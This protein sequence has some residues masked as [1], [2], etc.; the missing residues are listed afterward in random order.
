MKESSIRISGNEKMQLMGNLATMLAAG[1][2]ILETVDS[3]LEESKGN[4]TK[5][6]TTLKND[7]NEG[8]LIHTSFARFPQS[9]DKVTVNLIKAAE[10]AGN[11]ETVLKDIKDNIRK[12][13]EF[14]DKVK[15]AMMYPIFVMLIFIGVMVMML[16]V[17]I[18]KIAQVFTRLKMDL[19]LAT[20]VLIVSSNALVKNPVISISVCVAIVAI[21]IA[22][23]RFKRQW[24][25]NVIFSLPFLSG[26][27]RQIDLTRFSRSFSLLLDSGLPILIA[28]DLSKEVILKNDLKKLITE[29]R[30]KVESGKQFSDGLGSEQKIMS[31]MVVKLIEVGERT[32]SLNQSMKD[33]S[34]SLNYEV[35]KR[36][37]T[38]TALLEPI[39]LVGVGLAVGAMMLSIIGPIYGLI[40]SVGMK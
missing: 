23:F 26:I 9:F 6:L 36:L 35:T 17:V 27:M 4:Q 21:F 10:K 14:S 38:A 30:D 5:V 29:A 7:L 1:I 18:P 37:E 33:I 32:G 25:T 40:S 3:L 11:L 13:M 19:P 28:I 20:K 22:L 24:I 31:G 39:M 15:S 2:P 16:V 34:E 12:D 8:N